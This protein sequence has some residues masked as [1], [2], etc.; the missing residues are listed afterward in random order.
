MLPPY[1][2]YQDSLNLLHFFHF[3]NM[4]GNSILKVDK[5]SRD[6]F[7]KTAIAQLYSQ[8]QP[9]FLF[10]FIFRVF[11][12]RKTAVRPLLSGFSTFSNLF[13]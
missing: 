10:F 9:F 4:L 7:L 6:I 3:C 2:K 1:K 13:C 8:L 12:P 5:K 11:S